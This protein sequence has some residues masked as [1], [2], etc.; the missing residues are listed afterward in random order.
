LHEAVST[1]QALERMERD[2]E[3]A[4][5]YDRIKKIEQRA[6]VLKTLYREYEAVRQDAERVILIARHRIG[7]ELRA[8]P[9]ARGAQPYQSTVPLC[10]TAAPTLAEQVGSA[11][12][13][14]RL[15]K[16]AEIAREDMLAAAQEIWAKGKGSDHFRRG[17]LAR[18]EADGPRPDWPNISRAVDGHL[19]R[20]RRSW[21]AGT[22]KR[23]L[24]RRLDCG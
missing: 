13:G 23:R 4:G 22:F 12:R 16:L 21:R 9:V 15:K 3:A 7:E 6:Q 17:L 14:W 18:R 20:G 19:D 11:Q 24:R 8:A 10:G 2:V 1:R 5:T